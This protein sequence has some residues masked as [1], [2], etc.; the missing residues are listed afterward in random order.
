MNSCSFNVNV[1]RLL[2][3]ASLLVLGACKSEPKTT[4]TTASTTASA[5]S[6][7]KKSAEIS[8]EFT[9][10]AEVT[11]LEPEQRLVTL[12]REDGTQFGLMVGDGVRNFDQIKVGDDV[13]V[14]YKEV[15]TALK[16]PPGE[17]A[18]PIE[19]KIA[20]A[21]AKPG[22]KPAMGVGI[23]ATVRVKIESIDRERDIVVFSLASG[24][25]IARRLKTSQGREFVKNIAVGDTVQLD[26]MEALALGVEKL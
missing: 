26:Y 4:N 20:A 17:A 25:L 22:E 15:L 12:R 1:L 18:R 7:E 13:K 3:P 16:L 14:R 2:L 11:A 21:R 5:T 6:S 10:T 23:A 9:A 8:N 19:G 24:E